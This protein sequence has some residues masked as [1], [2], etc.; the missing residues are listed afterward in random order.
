VVRLL[1]INGSG[2][3]VAFTPQDKEQVDNQDRNN[4]AA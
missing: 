1:I 2:L 3:F 4:R